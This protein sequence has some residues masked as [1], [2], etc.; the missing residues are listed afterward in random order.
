[1][2]SHLF[3]FSQSYGCN[4]NPSGTSLIV[5]NILCD[6]KGNDDASDDMIRFTVT[7]EN[8]RSTERISGWNTL[9]MVVSAEPFDN[10]NFDTDNNIVNFY[11]GATSYN[12]TFNALSPGCIP[13]NLM[14][15]IE[16]CSD[17]DLLLE[18]EGAYV[19]P[20]L[21]QWGFTFLFL[22]MIII[23]LVKIKSRP[24]GPVYLTSGY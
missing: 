7:G 22:I 24:K 1:M 4:E 11:Y 21:S 15:S 20:T 6:D 5:S 17:E 19:I 9:P 2:F 10:V 18:P 3:L 14:V 23:G 12:V 16:D 13:L 8:G